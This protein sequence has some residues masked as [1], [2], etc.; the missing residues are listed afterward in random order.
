ME[1]DRRKAQRVRVNLSARWEGVLEQREATVTSLS[2][3]GCFL[4]S[5]GEVEPKELLRVEIY[6]PDQEPLYA[7]AEVVDEAYDIGFAVQFT[8]LEAKDQARLANFILEFPST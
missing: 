3:S 5:G 2:F 8:L 7:W 1:P 6:F 4:L